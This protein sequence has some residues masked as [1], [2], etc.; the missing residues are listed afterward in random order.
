MLPFK[1]F[2]KPSS[3]FMSNEDSF[4]PWHLILNVKLKKKK[5]TRASQWHA[6][7]YPHTLIYN[8]TMFVQNEFW[9]PQAGALTMPP[10][11]TSK[12]QMRSSS[13]HP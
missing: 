11:V 13:P 4:F 12:F 2:R 5:E 3:I 1:S 8:M 6:I 9:A 10:G 7:A